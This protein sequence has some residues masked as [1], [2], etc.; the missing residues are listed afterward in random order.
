MMMDRRVAMIASAAAAAVVSAATQSS[1]PHP[2]SLPC[3][4]PS[5][6]ASV[7]P[8]CEEEDSH[9]PSEKRMCFYQDDQTTVYSACSSSSGASPVNQSIDDPV[10]AADLF[11]ASTEDDSGFSSLYS[12]QPSSGTT[13]GGFTDDVFSSFPSL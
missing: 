13:A 4:Q 5:Q 2:L 1:P 3:E 12:F 7:D 10:D 6:L 8:A 9:Q 11:S